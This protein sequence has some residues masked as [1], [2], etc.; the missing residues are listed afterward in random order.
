MCVYS[1]PNQVLQEMKRL[2]QPSGHILLLEN[3]IS[4]N[5]LLGMIQHIL[6]PIITPLSRECRWDVDVPQLV[7][8]TALHTEYTDTLQ[9][10]SILF[11]SYQK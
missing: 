9:Q 7:S 3:T 8:E 6:S 5:P 11:G 4:T 10:G 1:H 2:V